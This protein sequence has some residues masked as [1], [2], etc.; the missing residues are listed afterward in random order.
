[1]GQADYSNVYERDF[2]SLF[3][4][5]TQEFY[6]LESLSYLS[7]N[8]ATAYVEKAQ[9]RIEEE[10]DRAKALGLASTTE[11]P[12]KSIVETEL[13][14]RHARALVDMEHSGFASLLTDE[15]KLQ[16]MRCMF[17]L[18]ARVPLSTICAMLWRNASKRTGVA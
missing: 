9:V 16:E 3:L 12:L 17:D 6:R 1:L 11:E 7:Q 2:E 10:K 5:T 18:F 15:T 4:G 13:I 14:E 8:T